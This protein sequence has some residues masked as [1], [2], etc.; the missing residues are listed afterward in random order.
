MNARTYFRRFVDDH[1]VEAPADLKTLPLAHGTRTI[2]IRDVLA[3]GEIALPDKPCKTLRKKLIFSFYGRPSYRVNP[4]SPS[5]KRPASAPSFMLLK[6][7]AFEAAALAHPLDTGAFK[8]EL[9][10][11]QVDTALNAVDFGFSP[12]VTDVKKIVYHFFGSN[13]TYMQNMPREGLN[14]PHGHDEAQA[15]YD[16]I[17]SGVGG[18]R[19]E[20]DSSIEITL[21]RAIPIE[22]EWVEC[23]I[24]PDLLLDAEY[25]GLAAKNAGINTR[26][27]RF[28]P[29]FSPKDY[30]SRIFDAVTDY[31]RAKK[32]L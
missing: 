26:S 1:L 18:R 19:D 4:A 23:L 31:Y 7:K 24:V 21:D 32:L 13:D 22:P 28:M 29:G 25:Y 15:Y 3:A 8:L 11:A 20:R 17:S 5:L 9:Y 16:V 14:V 10:E 2:F 30:T 27:Y 12:T 6:P